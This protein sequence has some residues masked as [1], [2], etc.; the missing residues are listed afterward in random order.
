[1]AEPVGRAPTTEIGVSGFRSW[2]G[3]VQSEFLQD[4]RGIR[5][6]RIYQEMATDPILSG[7]LLAIESAFRDR[8][9]I[10]VPGGES[11]A[12]VDAAAFLE[13]C[14]N[15]MSHSWSDFIS[16]LIGQFTF[17]WSWFEIVYKVRSGSETD[18]SSKATDGRFGWRKFAYRD[19]LTLDKWD[20]DQRGGLQGM[21]QRPPTQVSSVLIPIS[22]SLHFKTRH[23]GGNPEGASIF[24]GAYM[25]WYY[26]KHLQAL[27]AISLE[28]TGGGIPT[29]KMP[30]GYTDT[31]LTAAQDAIRRF[32]VDEQMGFTLPPGWELELAFGGAGSRGITD[33]FE[34]AITR[35]TKEMVLSTL[36]QVL[37]LGMEKVGSYALSRTQRDLFQVALGGWLRSIEDV[38]NRFAV[39]RLFRANAFSGLTALPKISLGTIGDADVSM[40]IDALARLVPQGVI[41]PDDELEGRVREVLD[42]PAASE[43]TQGRRPQPVQPGE[44]G[45]PDDTAHPFRLDWTGYP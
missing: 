38:I 43:D 22:R 12:D 31:D 13:S 25:P 16:D 14:V 32:K 40:L 1:M 17:G 45:G 21:W 3:Q 4:L 37:L 44:G 41:I 33:G 7:I 5:G 6:R 2:G 36:T 39:E 18:P 9:P 10:V 15:D 34:Q 20:F 42:L 35:Y 30:E 26:R 29:I 28:R 23:A 19:Q 8:Q 24:R 27:E 11:P